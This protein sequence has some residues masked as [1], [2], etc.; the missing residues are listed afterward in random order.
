MGTIRR[1]G[2]MSCKRGNS[3]FEARNPKQIQRQESRNAQN[4]AIKVRSFEFRALDFEFVSDFVFRAS[5]FNTMAGASSPN[6]TR[7]HSG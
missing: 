2:T 1:Q 5:D 6:R 4:G 3:K 7:R